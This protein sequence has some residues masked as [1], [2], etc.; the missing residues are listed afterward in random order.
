[1]RSWRFDENGVAKD[2]HT[3]DD[4]F[5][6]CI[7]SDV[8]VGISHGCGNDKEKHNEIMTTLENCAYD[9]ICIWKGFCFPADHEET[10]NLNGLTRA[11]NN[12]K[13]SNLLFKFW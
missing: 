13:N 3:F 4:T 1:M 12:A 11:F 7:P 6:I 8:S 2:A 9:Y 10:L 5:G